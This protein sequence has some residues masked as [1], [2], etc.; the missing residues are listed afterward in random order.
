MEVLIKEQVL[1]LEISMR[2]TAAMDV[3][4]HESDFGSVKLNQPV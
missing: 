2:N 4:K 1:R 3:L